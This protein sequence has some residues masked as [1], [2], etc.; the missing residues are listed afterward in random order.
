MEY[1][2]SQAAIVFF[3]FCFLLSQLLEI[4][5]EKDAMCDN[6]PTKPTFSHLKC[7]PPSPQLGGSS[8]SPS[9]PAAATPPAIG[10]AAKPV[11][12]KLSQSDAHPASEARPQPVAQPQPSPAPAEEPAKDAAMVAGVAAAAAASPASDRHSPAVPQ[13]ARTPGSEEVRSETT[14]RTEGVTE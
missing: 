13:P 10:E 12:A 3:L 8:S 6:V 9:S 7:S 4:R 11:A 2:R 14:E 1:L 5:V